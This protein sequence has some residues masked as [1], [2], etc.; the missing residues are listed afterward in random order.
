MNFRYLYYQAH[1]QVQY[2]VVPVVFQV[3]NHKIFQLR[4]G[5][6]FRLN[7]I[8]QFWSTHFS[9]KIFRKLSRKLKKKFPKNIFTKMKHQIFQK[10]IENT[11]RCNFVK[12]LVSFITI[13]VN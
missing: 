3:Q 1:Y 9:A 13:F 4:Q 6:T 8:G 5:I 7:F 10:K 11:F 2:P 12:F